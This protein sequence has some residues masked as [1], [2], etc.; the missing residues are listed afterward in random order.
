MKN[1]LAELVARREELKTSI[2]ELDKEVGQHPETI[3]N[4]FPHNPSWDMDRFEALVGRVGF[5][6]EITG[7][8]TDFRKDAYHGF[9]VQFDTKMYRFREGVAWHSSIFD[10]GEEND[11]RSLDRRV[12]EKLY[13][14]N[15]PITCLR[16]EHGITDDV[17]I[18]G[19]LLA[20][21]LDK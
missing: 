4:T 14:A 1:T 20:A 21:A 10:Y 12:A 2:V 16:E 18:L 15:D 3:R 8:T 7:N 17:T 5:I 6:K 19:Y 11:E 13:Y 9:L